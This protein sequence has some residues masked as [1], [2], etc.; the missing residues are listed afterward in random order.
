MKSVKR[1]FVTTAPILAV[2]WMVIATGLLQ[3]QDWNR[4]RGPNGSGISADAM[5]PPVTWSPQSN[6]KWK[7]ALPGAGASCPIVVGDHI[8][9]SCYSGYGESRDNLGNM[10]NLKRHVVCVNR[11][12]GSIAWS[13]TIDAVLPEDEFS[14]MGVPEHGYASHTPVSDGEN[15]YFFLGKSGVYA[16][17]FEGNQLWHKSVGTD[18]DERK[19]GS[20][21]S[22]ILHEDVLV[23]PAIAESRKIYGL[24]KQTGEEVWTQDNNG[25]INST[26]CT[27]AIVKVDD[28]RTDIVMGI[29]NQIIGLDPQTGSIRWFCNDVPSDSF[30]SS[31]VEHDGII[32]AAVGNR[33]GGGS[34][35]VKAGGEG[36]VTGSHV[37]WNGS[38]R[39][40]YGT[41]VIHGDNLFLV[42]RNIMTTIRIADGSEGEKIRVGG[43][44]ASGEA[45][46]QGRRRGGPGGGD[47]ASPIVA[48]GKLYFVKRNG[49]THVFDAATMQELTIN[50]VTEDAEDFAATPAVSD[51][52]I[53]LRSNKHL[54]C[55]DAG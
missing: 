44:A 24:N 52:Q 38:T 15:V 18:S 11:A 41:P 5:R 39:N 22:P 50:K 16:F 13:K 23:V 54:Y 37:V 4:F 51:G 34:L 49:D 55:V 43:G 28:Q 14:G 32:Y 31:I 8:F 19:W 53:F 10:Q 7:A 47:Y 33:T 3:G 6:V 45:R 1:V 25:G 30:Y 17:D 40:S 35:A 21:A 2:A 48:G 42:A 12:D 20:A 36:D 27:P 46:G 26:W 29:P 9:L